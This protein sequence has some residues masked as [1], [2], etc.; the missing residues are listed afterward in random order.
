[1]LFLHKT[2]TQKVM[3]ALQV[4]IK[5]RIL[6]QILLY[7]MEKSKSYGQIIVFKVHKVVNSIII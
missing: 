2:F 6:L 5:V 4:H 7:L 3:L 1:M